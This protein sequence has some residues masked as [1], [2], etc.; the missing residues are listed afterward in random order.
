MFNETVVNAK[1]VDWGDLN[2]RPLEC[3][4][5]ISD[6]F[7]RATANGCSKHTQRDTQIDS[8]LF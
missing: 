7:G 2:P 4:R 5:P 3:K 6:V 1:K 8:N